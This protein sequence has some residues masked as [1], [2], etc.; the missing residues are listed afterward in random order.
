MPTIEITVEIAQPR[1]TVAQAFLDPGNAVYWTNDLDRFEIVSG[2][3]GD[4]GSVAHL[5][6]ARNGRRYVLEDILEETVRDRY[7][8]SRVT[9]GGMEAVVETWLREKSG[10]TVVAIRWSGSGTT[11]L[12]RLLLPLLRGAL[13]RQIRRE[14]DVF[15]ALVET[16]GAHFCE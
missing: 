7:F 1:A 5:H 12:M 6:Y 15:K 13:R 16:R 8:R 3:P 9:G 14:L 2:T 4:V 10:G 11:I